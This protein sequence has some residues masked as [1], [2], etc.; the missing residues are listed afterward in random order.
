MAGSQVL[1]EEIS[2]N[3]EQLK[4]LDQSKIFIRKLETGKVS[5]IL[6]LRNYY[7]VSELAKLALLHFLSQKI[8]LVPIEEWEI[9]SVK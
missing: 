1:E 5:R 7:I 4:K 6:L 9:I 2:W 3:T 8:I